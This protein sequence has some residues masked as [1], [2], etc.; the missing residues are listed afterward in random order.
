MGSDTT[1]AASKAIEPPPSGRPS[2]HSG[3]VPLLSLPFLSLTFLD[4]LGELVLPVAGL[5]R[6]LAELAA[7]AFLA[8]ALFYLPLARM[9]GKGGAGLPALAE[10]AFGRRAGPWLLGLLLIGTGVGLM[11]LFVRD[12]V[13][14]TLRGL[15]AVGLFNEA[16]ALRIE[17]AGRDLGPFVELGVALAWCLALAAVAASTVL[18]RIIAALGKLAAFCLA[19]AWM[20]LMAWC[21]WSARAEGAAMPPVPAGAAEAPRYVLTTYILGFAAAALFASSAEWGAVLGSRR[22]IDRAGWM[23]V[24]VAIASAGTSV[25]A[26]L[27]IL[28]PT[29]TG[30]LSVRGAVLGRLGG[31]I[32]AAL[33]WGF[34]LGLMALAVFSAATA[35]G[36]LARAF[37]NRRQLPWAFALG[38]AAFA[39]IASG[40]ADRPMPL[41]CRLSAFLA[42][43]IGALGGWWLRGGRPDSPR[44]G[45]GW[46]TLLAWGAGT[47]VGLL[48]PAAPLGDSSSW[49][50]SGPTLVAA[51]LLALIVRALFPAPRPDRAPKSAG[52]DPPPPEAGSTG[53]GEGLQ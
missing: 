38:A 48:S 29:S 50:R 14:L 45:W 9:G 32:E 42:P 1:T 28:G 25:L 53:G 6:G 22:E 34:A 2:W 33:S 27:T 12:A 37:P 21:I 13:D 40:I 41:A 17:V 20:G 19:L 46:A 31:T 5:P 23:G 7:S 24:A 10:S 11:A 18:T 26:I 30:D 16:K 44:K 8:T 36:P 35:L 49:L 39:L 51:F 52:D 43:M 15:D 47:A 4:S 3:A